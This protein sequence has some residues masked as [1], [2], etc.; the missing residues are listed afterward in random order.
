MVK[1]DTE[2][3][4][5]TTG[6]KMFFLHP[7]LDDGQEHFLL[8]FANLAEDGAG[9]TVGTVALVCIELQHHTAAQHRCIGAVGK[10]RVVGVDGVGI[11]SRDQEGLC[12]DTVRTWAWVFPKE[13]Q[14][15]GESGSIRLQARRLQS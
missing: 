8:I 3:G 6:N 15:R 10:F 9:Y 1:G 2:C 7:S 14:E 13:I 11:V 5:L 12:Q 4:L